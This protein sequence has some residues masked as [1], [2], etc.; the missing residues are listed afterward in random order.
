MSTHLER[1]TVITIAA[2]L[3]SLP[4]AASDWENVLGL[5]GVGASVT[6]TGTVRDVFHRYAASTLLLDTDDPWV[7]RDID[8]HEDYERWRWD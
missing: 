5:Y 3:M 8:T 7:A 2:L 4:A 1:T 6:G